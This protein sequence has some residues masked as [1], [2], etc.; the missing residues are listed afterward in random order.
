MVD[1]VLTGSVQR[2]NDRIRVNAQLL[3]VADGKPVWPVSSTSRVADIL[4]MQDHVSEQL[5]RALTLE[6]N[7][8]ERRRMTRHY[9]E[10]VEAYELYLKGNDYWKK[11]TREGFQTSIEYLQR[12]LEKDPEYALA[13]AGLAAAHTAQSLFGFSSPKQAMPASGSMARR[14]LT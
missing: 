14:A 11:R 7:G 2:A 12:A 13:Y 8:D 4:T 5:A 9:T 10:N 3:R 1:A 6:L